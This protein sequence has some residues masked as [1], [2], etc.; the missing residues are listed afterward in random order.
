MELIYPEIKLQSVVK[1]YNSFTDRTA[2]LIQLLEVCKARTLSK[3]LNYPVFDFNEIR[4]YMDKGR[5]ETVSDKGYH[6][7]WFQDVYKMEKIQSFIGIIP[8]PNQLVINE[9]IKTL[10]DNPFLEMKHYELLVLAPANNFAGTNNV[11]ALDP[12]V[13]CKLTVRELKILIPLTQW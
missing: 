10:L 13:F 4:N 8:M 7:L 9:R 2:N 12:V 5:Y 1:N 6:E 11:Q 3:Y